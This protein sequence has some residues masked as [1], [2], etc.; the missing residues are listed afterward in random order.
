MKWLEAKRR[1]APTE[2]WRSFL[3]DVGLVIIPFTIV[4]VAVPWFHLHFITGTILLISLPYIFLL[5]ALRGFWPAMLAAIA[6]CILFDFFLIL[7]ILRNREIQRHFPTSLPPVEVD[8]ILIGQVLINLVENA[9]RHTPSCSSIELNARTDHNHLYVSVVD[10]GHG[11]PNSEK[12][13]IFEKFYRIEESATEQEND[14]PRPGS[15]LGLA[16]CRGLVQAHEGRIW[17][18]DTPGG[19]ATFIFTL[20][21]RK[22]GTLYEETYYGH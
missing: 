4:I 20:P 18:E 13:R 2:R 21:V 10:H 3:I 9:V 12:E 15:G 19:G 16:V 17:V 14:Q 1:I 5:I 11:I 6:A 8:D 7:A 22:T